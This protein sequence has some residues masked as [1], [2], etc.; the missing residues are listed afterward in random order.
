MSKVAWITTVEEDAADSDLSAAYEQCA[1]S[2]TGRA[3][4]IYKV[5]SLNPRS[6]LDHRA[7]YRTLMFGPSPLKRY[8]REMI[9]TLVSALNQCHY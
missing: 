2:T 5:H 4:H 3:A 9:G 1:S 8:Q 6:M 7:L